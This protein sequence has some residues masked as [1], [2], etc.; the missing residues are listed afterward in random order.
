M[1]E[2]SGNSSRESGEQLA[3]SSAGQSATLSNPPSNPD[4]Q[5]R[6]NPAIAVI[7][8]R[9]EAIREHLAD[10][11]DNDDD[12][13]AAERAIANSLSRVLAATDTAFCAAEG[14]FGCDYIEWANTLTACEQEFRRT[15]VNS[16]RDAGQPS[17][18]IP[19]E[20]GPLGPATGSPE[21]TEP[22]PNRPEGEI[23]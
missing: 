13:P 1:T 20:S 21:P 19:S 5:I 12:R 10:I 2:Q 4:E 14:Q 9:W 8:D 7:L 15:Y 17:I 6:K 11:S 23:E 3:R 22:E 18:P 16:R